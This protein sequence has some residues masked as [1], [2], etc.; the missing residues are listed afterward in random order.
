MPGRLG[1]GIVAGA[2]PTEG[3]WRRLT[4]P[5][6][7]GALAFTLMSLTP[8]LLPRTAITQGIVTGI[9]AAIG[10]GLGA[11]TASIGR[12]FADRVPQPPT[13]RSWQ[14]LTVTAAV[15]LLP[16]L[17]LARVWQSGVREL[18]GVPH[19]PL[20]PLVL[21]PLVASPVFAALV[22]VARLLATAAHCLGGW[23]A[24]WMGV[25]AA[26][27]LGAIVVATLVV[28]LVSGLL[29]DGFIAVADR[30]FATRDTG[31]HDD[32][33]QPTNGLRSG[34]PGSLIAWAPSGARA[35]GSRAAA[36][37][38]PTS[39]RSMAHRPRRRSARTPGSRPRLTP[40]NEHG[41]PSTT[42][43]GPVGSTEPTCW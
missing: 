1:R 10:Y 38:A 7:W 4:V 42:S 26:R 32:A 37:P 11:L 20:W 41:S 34:G 14:V 22:G 25:R 2:A 39:P 18:M 31:T 35:A 12:A 30:V 33:T 43:N 29:V 24:G 28:L 23:L 3:F 8:S 5:G 36:P 17:V 19:P 27:T 6:L 21:V 15:T 13:P 40:R 9:S 16:I